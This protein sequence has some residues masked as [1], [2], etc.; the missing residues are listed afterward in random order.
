VIGS[1]Q[2]LVNCISLSLEDFLY[3]F[4]PTRIDV[5]KLGEK[6]IWRMQSNA[7]ESI[8]WLAA[9]NCSSTASVFALKTFYITLF[10]QGLMSSNLVKRSFGGCRVMLMRVFGGWQPPTA[11]QLH[12]SLP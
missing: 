10:L 6:M 3:N 1:F 2:L 9:S 8:W 4:S 12:H 7:N 5:I 11:R